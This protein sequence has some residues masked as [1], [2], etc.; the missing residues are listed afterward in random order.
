MSVGGCACPG[1]VLCCLIV[2]VHVVMLVVP[3]SAGCSSKS[4]KLYSP[5]EPPNGSAFP[6]FH[7]GTM[8]DR[9]VG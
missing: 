6:P 8:L 1:L 7:P 9:D 2:D 4:F 3:L 5:K